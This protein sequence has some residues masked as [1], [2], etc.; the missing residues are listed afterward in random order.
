MKR[1]ENRKNKLSRE[2][3][4]NGFSS[5]IRISIRFNILN[6]S[7]KVLSLLS[8]PD[9]LAKYKHSTSATSNLC[10]SACMVNSVS[11]SKPIEL[12]G[13]D[14]TNCLENILNPEKRSSI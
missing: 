9:G 11:I 10:S 2:K 12:H 7:P 13:K 3:N 4:K 8:D 6:P 1:D 5:F 14:F